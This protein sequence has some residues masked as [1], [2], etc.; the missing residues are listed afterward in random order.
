MIYWIPILRPDGSRVTDND[1]AMDKAVH[2]RGAMGQPM[3]ALK[4]FQFVDPARMDFTLK[5][6]G[7]S[8]SLNDLET[9]FEYGGTHGYAG[10][11]GD[12][13]GKYTFEIEEV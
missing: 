9:L 10:E 6:L 7:K 3:N 12:G 4:T 11:R 8:V 2:V 5:V 1:G 13:E